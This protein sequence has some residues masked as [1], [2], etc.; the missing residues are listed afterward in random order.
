MLL[1]FGF[2]PKQ[3]EPCNGPGPK[4]SEWIVKHDKVQERDEQEEMSRVK[5]VNKTEAEGL[6]HLQMTERKSDQELS[7]SSIY[8]EERVLRLMEEQEVPAGSGKCT[9]SS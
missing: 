6:S 4:K 1:V 7:G 3:A 5:E 2:L 9:D 8:E